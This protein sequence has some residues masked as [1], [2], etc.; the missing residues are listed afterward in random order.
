MDKLILSLPGSSL[1]LD[2]SDTGQVPGTDL[3]PGG[4]IEPKVC[5]RFQGCKVNKYF[6]PL[7]FSGPAFQRFKKRSFCTSHEGPDISP[8]RV[9]MTREILRHNDSSKTP[10]PRTRI[11]RDCRTLS[12]PFSAHASTGLQTVSL[13][14]SIIVM[15][16]WWST[17]MMTDQLNPKDAL[18]TG[19]IQINCP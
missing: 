10:T 11:L 14:Y 1:C 4:G 16:D 3:H 15:G 9:A 17:P 6:S 18:L 5:S 7:L 8:A 12:Q 2:S 19:Q 13:E